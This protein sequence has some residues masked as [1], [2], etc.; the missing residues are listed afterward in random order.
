MIPIADLS[1]GLADLVA[2]ASPSVVGV[3][4]R[5]GLGSGVVL[6]PDGWI[7][8]N[9][10]VAAGPGPLRVR[11][12]GARTVKGELA[13]ADALTDLA[14]VRAEARDLPPL[15]LAERRLRVGEIVLAIGNPLGFER[16]VTTGVVSA[17]H[18][19]LPAARGEV[20]EGLVQTDAAVNPGNSGGPLVDAHGAV[21]GITT[22]MLPWAHGIGFA[23]PAHTAS[24]I[25][26]VLIRDGSVRRPFL[27]VSARGED[28]DPADAQAAGHGRAVRVM[29]VVAGS[30]A[31]A[32][33]LRGGDLVVG[34]AGGPVE[35]LDDLVRAMVLG[36]EGA[37]RVD[38]LRGG[39][40]RQV[41]IR[42]RPAALAA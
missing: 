33:G 32:A 22:A 7:L 29:E 6:A 28:L 34:A 3:E 19:N 14:V 21:V 15:P 23:I 25:A 42:P 10:H 36:G 18:R 35:T 17:L 31:E 12:S 4:H 1:S 16:S 37:L 38:V 8:T 26:S 24:W 39:G 27:G 20:L 41:E 9:A 2:L 5:R 11:L 40:L 30:P 13:G